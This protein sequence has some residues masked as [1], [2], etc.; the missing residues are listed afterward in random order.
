MNFTK[1]IVVHTSVYKMNFTNQWHTV[2]HDAQVHH[3][4]IDLF[5]T[6]HDAFHFNPH[7]IADHI[8]NFLA[9]HQRCQC[10][11]IFTVDT[12]GIATQIIW[13][14]PIPTHKTGFFMKTTNAI[15]VKKDWRSKNTNV[16][17]VVPGMV[18]V[19]VV[20]VHSCSHTQ[21]RRRRRRR[22]RKRRKRRKQSES[23]SETIKHKVVDGAYGCIS[24]I[25]APFCFQP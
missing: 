4:L 5:I 11:G 12:N 20:V 1:R 22:R 14:A 6:L 15:I 23:S 24:N 7:L 25:E 21:R 13:C 3:H 9:Q 10:N 17:W 19:V 8:Q 18:V 16:V 2:W